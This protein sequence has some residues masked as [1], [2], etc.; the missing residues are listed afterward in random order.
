MNPTGHLHKP[1]VGNKAM[2]N[3]TLLTSVFGLLMVVT[4]SSCGPSFVGVR[5][6]Y[7]PGWGRGPGFGPRPFWGYRAPVVVGPRYCPPP[8]VTYRYYNPRPYGNPGWG[9]G[10]RRW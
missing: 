4:L 6:G 2:K 9:R 10:G 8:R 5:G 7:G 3:R 1:P